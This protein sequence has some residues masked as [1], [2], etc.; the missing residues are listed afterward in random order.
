MRGGPTSDHHVIKVTFF[1]TLIEDMNRFGIYGILSFWTSLG[2]LKNFRQIDTFV[3]KKWSLTN[4][5]DVNFF[6]LWGLVSGNGHESFCAK[7]KL[8]TNGTTFSTLHCAKKEKCRNF[9]WKFAK[10]DFVK[11][12]W[13]FYYTALMKVADCIFL[14]TMY[15]LAF[16]HSGNFPYSLK[17][18]T[19]GSAIHVKIGA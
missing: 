17:F 12:T 11:Y 1:T 8:E 7:V 16:A 3:C 5:V 13:D 14:I 9:L 15:I 2:N 19:T 4:Q 18:L 6:L 10:N